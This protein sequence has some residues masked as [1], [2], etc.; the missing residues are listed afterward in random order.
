MFF[1][2][3]NFVHGVHWTKFKET[4]LKILICKK[5]FKNIKRN[6]L[7]SDFSGSLSKPGPTKR[8][9]SKLPHYTNPNP[10]PIVNLIS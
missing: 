2:G 10:N 4:L 3:R 8:E 1:L 5:N 9:T 7:N 6:F